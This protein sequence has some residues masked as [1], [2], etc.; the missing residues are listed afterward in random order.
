MTDPRAILDGIESKLLDLPEAKFVEIVHLLEQIG[1]HP[2][3]REAIGTVRPRI[4]QVRPARR[5]TLRRVFCDPFEDLLVPSKD[6]TVPLRPIDRA[7]I[8]SLWQVVET[9]AG[10]DE[11]RPLH[12][13]A[14]HLS[15]HDADE[16][17][18]L[19]CRVWLIAGRVLRKA[20]ADID[21]DPRLRNAFIGGGEE[22]LEQARDI[23]ELLD[24]G[25]AVARVK[26]I[27]SP[28]PVTDLG[29]GDIARIGE[30]VQEV[31]R[32]APHRVY[33]LLLI[34]ASR[35]RRPADLL[36][37]LDGLDFGRARRN[38]AEVCAK[39]S[40]LAVASLETSGRAGAGQPPGPEVA[41]RAARILDSLA[42]T[43]SLLEHARDE[44][45]DSR[46]AEVRQAVRTMVDAGLLDAAETT[47]LDG[48]PAPT[49]GGGTL[50]MPDPERQEKA[51]DY[52]RAL[53]RCQVFAGE[54]G[55]EERVAATLESI[56]NTVHARLGA[57]L[58]MAAERDDEAFDLSVAYALRLLE[59]VRGL[60]SSP[61]PQTDV[62]RLLMPEGDAP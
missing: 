11:L 2:R 22:R 27:L 19:G 7:I 16:R 21:A 43:R 13:K 44:R 50:A 59:L 42:A 37:A 45:Y 23:V 8:A 26:A 29:E 60:S 28:R 6:G 40:G 3:V 57:L 48:L 12:R 25:H 4:A 47:I 51:E 30:L 24:S 38:K 58:D 1:D 33:H 55:L 36:A 31:A 46:L 34:A 17:H 61:S 10:P 53:R 56:G 62:L 5:L 35:L 49:A 54:L 18:T 52:A 20:L 14:G 41:D 39:L 9:C 15:D 32:A